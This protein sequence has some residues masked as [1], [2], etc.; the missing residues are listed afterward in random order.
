MDN[1]LFVCTYNYNPITIKVNFGV[2]TWQEAISD[3]MRL[4]NII[5]RA[6]R[7]G[8]TQNMKWAAKEPLLGLRAQK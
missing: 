3:S 6:I 8:S 4:R 2:E 5:E 7:P 1:P